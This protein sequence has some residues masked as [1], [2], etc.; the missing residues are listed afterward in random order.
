M[1]AAPT[2]VTREEAVDRLSGAFLSGTATGRQLLDNDK[3]TGC[4]APGFGQDFGAPGSAARIKIA[5]EYN[6]GREEAKYKSAALSVFRGHPRA[7]SPPRT[8]IRSDGTGGEYV[9]PGET[10]AFNPF[11]F[12][13]PSFG[14]TTP[15]EISANET[16]YIT[17][18][19]RHD[20][21]SIPDLQQ[22]MRE[23]FK[24]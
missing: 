22:R 7:V 8:S 1:D 15:D 21:V 23:R 14:G 5:S 13:L 10:P 9:R 19:L 17:E 2:D 11:D 4:Y 24:K 6:D 20:P 18:S 16:A 3:L 12:S